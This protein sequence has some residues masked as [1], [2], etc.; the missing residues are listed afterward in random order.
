M[1]SSWRLPVI[2]HVQLCSV[3]HSQAGLE[4]FYLSCSF[5]ILDVLC[6]TGSGQ[7]QQGQISCLAMVSVC[8]CTKG[9]RSIYLFMK[10]VEQ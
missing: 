5:A 1:S 6:S 3:Q 4:Y 10:M 7:L 9:S 8:S 2:S